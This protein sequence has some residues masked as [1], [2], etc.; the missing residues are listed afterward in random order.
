MRSAAQPRFLPLSWR[1]VGESGSRRPGARV[2]T[3]RQERERLDRRVAAVGCSL[4][5]PAVAGLSHLHYLKRSSRL[6][7]SVGAGIVCA[8][9]AAEG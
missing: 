4:C 7:R 3:R 5:Q 1:R 8:V 6:G 2:R 9:W